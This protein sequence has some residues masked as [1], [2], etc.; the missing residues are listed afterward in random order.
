MWKWM[1]TQR[2]EGYE[3][4]KVVAMVTSDEALAAVKRLLG[5]GVSPWEIKNKTHKR[6][7]TCSFE[8]SEEMTRHAPLCQLAGSW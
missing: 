8:E 2:A 4:P 7:C 1:A 6:R 5:P 3:D